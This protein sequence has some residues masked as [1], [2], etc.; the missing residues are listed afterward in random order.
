MLLNELSEEIMPLLSHI[1][2]DDKK[3]MK[4]FLLF[5]VVFDGKNA[6]LFFAFAKDEVLTMNSLLL[7]LNVILHESYTT[8]ETVSI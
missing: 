6:S 8:A 3:Y 4:R 2:T 1:S 5:P 7:Q